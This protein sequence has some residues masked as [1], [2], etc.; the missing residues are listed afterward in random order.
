MTREVVEEANADGDGEDAMD[1]ALSRVS[2][3]SATVVTQRITKKK[4][5]RLLSLHPS[6]RVLQGGCRQQASS[7]ARR[8]RTQDE[9]AGLERSRDAC[10]SP[11]ASSTN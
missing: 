2:F 5:G 7:R 11:Y 1:G 4:T 8:T 3:K 6:A 9:A 10:R